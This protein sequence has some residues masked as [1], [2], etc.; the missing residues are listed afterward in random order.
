MNYLKNELYELIKTE[1]TVFDFIQNVSLDG[2]W[3]RDV[4]NPEYEW[5]NPKFWLMLGYNPEEMRRKKFTEKYVIHPD[6]IESSTYNLNR[7]YENPNHPYDQVI[8]Y[9]HKNGSTVWTRCRGWAIRNKEGKAIRM[10]GTHIDITKEKESEEKLTL[11]LSSAMTGKGKESQEANSLS[12][13]SEDGYRTLF[14]SMDEGYCIIEMIFDE[15][16]KPIDYRF[17]VINAS[18]ERQTG[19]LNAVGKRMREFAPNHEEHWFEIYGRIALTG[20]PVRFENR[21]EQLH[22]WYDVYAFRFG[23]PRNMQVAILFNDIT[24]RKQSEET[25]NVLNTDLAHNLKQLELVNHDLESFSYSVSHDLRAPLRA[26][27][28]YAKI[29]GEDFSEILP[30][31]AKEYL[32]AI[33][34]NSQKMGALID[35]LLTFSRLGRKEI[36]TSTVDIESMVNNI[37]EDISGHSLIKKESFK[38]GKLSQATVD[39]TLIKQVW[40]NLILNAHKYSRN[41]PSPLIEISS[42]QNSTELLYSVKDNGVGFDMK[43]CSKLFG[44]FQRLHSENEFEGTGVG[45]A[46]VHKIITRHGGKIW[47]E[48]KINEGACFYFTIPIIHS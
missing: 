17:L 13:E 43:Y 10:L 5:R 9:A 44:V 36:Q 26:I 21:A 20:E 31:E 47:A 8:R 16:N 11:A 40:V 1:N 14:N 45:L 24:Q 28:G 12:W 30:E 2:L 46:I 38:V 6:D 34:K 48:A 42:S 23:E 19:L 4:E 7:H 3:Y 25:I 35:D 37:I 41:N 33:S 22:R 18:F 27:N 29:I 39:I 32:E 15:H